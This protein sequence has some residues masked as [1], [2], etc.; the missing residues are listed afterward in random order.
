MQTETNKEK[1]QC[2]KLR[3]KHHR[4]VKCVSK[5]QVLCGRIKKTVKEKRGANA[6]RFFALTLAQIQ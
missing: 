2:V 1:K 3:S 5:T 4:S 6:S